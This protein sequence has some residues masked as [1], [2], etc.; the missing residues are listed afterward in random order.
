M[1]RTLLKLFGLAALGGCASAR[2]EGRSVSAVVINYT[3]R[4][5]ADVSVNGRWAGAANA[6][7]G[8]GNRVEGFLAPRETD[9][10]VVLKVKWTVGS[11]YSVE[12][13]SYTRSPI[14]ARFADVELPMPYPP[15]STY[16]ILHFFP[17]GHVEA[18]LS[19]DRPARK[20]P[21]PAGYHR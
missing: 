1:K 2:G 14:Q 11:Y 8:E 20:I 19:A 10:K 7:G 6:Y 4:Y 5:I 21:K 15:E 12:S 9:K 3:D 16:L 13:N 17:D 18:E